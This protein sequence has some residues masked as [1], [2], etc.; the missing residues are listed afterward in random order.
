MIKKGFLLVGLII[1]TATLSSCIDKDYDLEDID[2]TAVAGR[3]VLQ[4]SAKTGKSVSFTH[5]ALA[6]HAPI[7]GGDMRRPLQKARSAGLRP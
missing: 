3:A 1:T 7:R 6:R 2:K 5:I 4:S